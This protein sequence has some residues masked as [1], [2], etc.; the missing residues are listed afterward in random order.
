MKKYLL[1]FCFYLAAYSLYSQSV[2]TYDLKKDIIIG[3]LSL[4]VFASPFF[5]ENNTICFYFRRFIYCIASQNLILSFN[6][7]GISR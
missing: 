6:S 2:F 5:V 3:G 4:G 1:V 7:E